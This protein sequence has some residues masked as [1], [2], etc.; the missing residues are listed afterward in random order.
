MLGE[1]F[2]FFDPDI[3]KTFD[4]FGNQNILVFSKFGRV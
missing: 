3:P 2:L 4:L 1:E